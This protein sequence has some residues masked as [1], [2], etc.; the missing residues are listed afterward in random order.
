MVRLDDGAEIL[1]RHDGGGAGRG[2]GLECQG[3][4]AG[5]RRTRTAMPGWSI[6][7]V[8]V[9]E[10]LQLVL[11]FGANVP[12]SGKSGIACHVTAAAAHDLLS[13]LWMS[14]IPKEL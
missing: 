13:M 10:A 14:Q 5:L 2:A 1:V 3:H 4:D 12:A 6:F 8:I 11:T 7:S 9:S